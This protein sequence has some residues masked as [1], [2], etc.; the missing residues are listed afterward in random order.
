MPVKCGSS[1]YLRKSLN[2]NP[3]KNGKL[4]EG[5]FAGFALSINMTP[6]ANGNFAIA[7][8]STVTIS[9]FAHNLTDNL[10]V[11]PDSADWGD[12]QA[13]I[14]KSGHDLVQV[15][16]FTAPA[17]PGKVGVVV[18]GF[19]FLPD[20]NGDFTPGANYTVDLAEQSSGSGQSSVT[21][22]LPV[23]PGGVVNRVY[24]FQTI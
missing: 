21:D 1:H 5:N 23:S 22:P 7:A 2:W 9:T 3:P 19:T 4:F 13:P 8:G 17:E 15:G 14:T 11:F 24:T 20:A 12:V 16:M 18:P 10:T 6:L